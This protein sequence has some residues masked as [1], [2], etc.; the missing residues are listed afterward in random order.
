MAQNPGGYSGETDRKKRCCTRCRL[1]AIAD[2][3]PAA[4]ATAMSLAGERRFPQRRASYRGARVPAREEGT[5]AASRSLAPN[6]ADLASGII[7]NKWLGHKTG[8][9]QEAASTA[10]TGRSVA[11]NPLSAI[12]TRV[13]RLVASN[14]S[15]RCLAGK[16]AGSKGVLAQAVTVLKQQQ[17]FA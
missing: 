15:V 5:L 9:P 7:R 10:S 13:A 1:V 3:Q 8:A 11:P 2:R 14:A 12:C 6:E 16:T 4:K 17:L